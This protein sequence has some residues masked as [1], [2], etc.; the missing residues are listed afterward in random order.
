MPRIHFGTELPVL[1]GH[2]LVY[3]WDPNMNPT[4]QFNEI[5]ACA[6]QEFPGRIVNNILSY[7]VADCPGRVYDI[8]GITWYNGYLL[9]C[10]FCG[11]T[12]RTQ[13]MDSPCSDAC[14]I[15]HIHQL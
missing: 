3:E 4:L 14:T 12:A 13:T 1:P 6:F 11:R 7:R 8:R 15:S 9:L 5:L 10:Q 2:L